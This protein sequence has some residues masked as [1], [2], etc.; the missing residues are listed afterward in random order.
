M[1]D[2]KVVKTERKFL[3]FLHGYAILVHG[4]FNVGG[5]F[6]YSLYVP[7]DQVVWC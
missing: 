2:V 1:N 3:A 7:Y 4:C 6:G 5:S